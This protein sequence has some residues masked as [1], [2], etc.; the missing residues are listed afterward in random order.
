M[1]S[2]QPED[3][4]VEK[5]EHRNHPKRDN[6]MECYEHP[7]PMTWGLDR[8]DQRHQLKYD[9]YMNKT[10]TFVYGAHTGSGVQIYVLDGGI[11]VDHPTFKGYAVNGF[12]A[13]S[14]DNDNVVSN[15]GHHIA[16][17]ASSR[18]FGSAKTANLIGVI[19]RDGFNVYSNDILEGL[20]WI[21]NDHMYRYE[22]DGVILKSIVVYPYHAASVSTISEALKE[23]DDA[24]G[25]IVTPSYPDIDPCTEEYHQM[26]ITVGKIAFVTYLTQ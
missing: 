18:D 11:F 21:Y 15:V 12:T 4:L 26:F 16:S 1:I 10:A 19:V 22:Q 6:E 2:N 8:I 9:G 7:S 17:L 5:Y 13:S 3:E 24:G 23:L 25:I 14:F 20:E